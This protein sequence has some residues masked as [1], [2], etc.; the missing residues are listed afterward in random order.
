MIKPT[1]L[2]IMDGWGLAPPGPGNA[3]SLA[4][5]HNIP[6]YWVSYPHTKLN[7]SGTSVGLPAREDGNTETG[8]INIGAGRVVYQDLPRINMAITDKTFYSNDAFIAAVNYANQHNSNIH[9]MGL[10]SDSGV[11]AS[12]DHLYALLECMKQAKCTRPVYLHL[13]TDGRDSPPQAATRFIDEVEMKCKEIG[14]GK[15]AT[16]MGR[17]Y[18]MDRDRRWERTQIAYTALT[19]V[20]DRK[21]ATAKIAIEES[22]KRQETDEFIKPT[23]ILDENGKPTPRIA[24]FDSVIFYNYRIDRP[25]QLTRAFVLSDF[26]TKPTTTSFDPYAVNYY[27]KHIVD[28]DDSRNTTF[29]RTVVLPDLYFVTMTEYER[30]LSCT[31]AYP[32]QPVKMS[33]GRVY[34]EKGLRQLRVSETEKERFVG[35]YFNGVREDPFV[36]EDRLIIP[37]PKVPTYDL[38]PDMSAYE[39]TQKLLDRITIGVYSLFVINFANADMVGHTGNI[40]QAIKACEVVDECVGKIVSTILNLQGTCIITADHGNVEEMLSEEGEMDTEHSTFPVPFIIID[41]VFDNNPAVLPTG[42]LGDIAPT[43]LAFKGLAIP[44]EMTGKNLLADLP[45]LQH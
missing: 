45:E 15:I 4:N 31:V 37:S 5:L 29:K 26:E 33:L 19:E 34:A 28:V 32:P 30:N 43:L 42:K 20:I 1:A 38:K 21:V 24:N 13:F 10:L 40:Q 27:H 14:I 35:F 17:Y 12:R 44:S 25:R 39:L 2:I 22:Y 16:I 8:H 9:L 23:I 7:A 36:G 18:G 3:I 11:H 6:K 41:H